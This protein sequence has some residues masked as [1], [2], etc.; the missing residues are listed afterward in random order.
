MANKTPHG[1]AKTHAESYASC[2]YISSQE[3]SIY[4]ELPD[5]ASLPR[6]PTPLPLPS[7]TG[8]LQFDLKS[9]FSYGV[10][11][12]VP[13]EPEAPYIS[14]RSSPIPAISS[15][16]DPLSS[17]MKSVDDSDEQ[18]YGPVDLCAENA[19]PTQ[20]SADETVKDRSQMIKKSIS[21]Q[22]LIMEPLPSTE[23]ASTTNDK[24]PTQ[25]LSS[26][27][28]SAAHTTSSEID[29]TTDE[30]PDQNNS[31]SSDEDV[32]KVHVQ[33]SSEVDTTTD[34]EPAQNLSPDECDLANPEDIDSTKQST[35][36]YPKRALTPICS[37]SEADT[38]QVPAPNL[39]CD[40]TGSEDVDSN[41][42]STYEYPQ[43]EVTLIS[44]ASE[45]DTTTNDV[46]VVVIPGQ[47]LPLSSGEQELTD[48]EDPANTT[49]YDYPTSS[50]VKT[51]TDNV[52]A[53]ND[54]K[55]RPPS[56]EYELQH[57]FKVLPS[58]GNVDD[59]ET[60]QSNS[61]QYAYD[62]VNNIKT[63][64]V[65]VAGTKTTSP[66]SSG[67]GYMLKRTNSSPVYL[68][69][70]SHSA[71]S[72]YIP[73]YSIAA[74]PTH[75]QLNILIQNMQQMQQTLAQMQSTYGQVGQ[76]FS[77]PSQTH[78]P[79]QAHEVVNQATSS[80]KSDEST[81]GEDS[82]P[83]SAAA[84]D[85]GTFS[86]AEVVSPQTTKQMKE[87]LRKLYTVFYMYV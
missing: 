62:Y 69:T 73:H 80:S 5:I 82:T 20:G 87:C 33:Y 54:K 64:P 35:Y 11:G 10:H 71:G 4:E 85:A 42:H 43:Q 72:I 25:N 23:S 22:S 1:V 29:P 34:E 74:D 70:R 51:I 53:F 36:K 83:D 15:A 38:D 14:M 7:D 27:E 19:V 65:A 55:P 18:I 66:S 75:V 39:T 44:G 63:C 84:Q 17:E 31:L 52:P 13:L 46:E 77:S 59:K 26:D 60:Q 68:Q 28:D 47:D 6:F 48:S 49:Y 56:D 67:S 57:D 81:H 61:D 86:A 32:N 24:V 58:T 30:V 37:A 50:A 16:E 21:D 2:E 45:V 40:L 78:V 8:S 41:E 76:A 79:T 12:K 9:N 3:E